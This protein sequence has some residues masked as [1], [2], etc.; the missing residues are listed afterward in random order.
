MNFKL[1][2]YHATKNKLL[3]HNKK[4]QNNKKLII[5]IHQHFK[6]AKQYL[7][8]IKPFYSTILFPNTFNKYKKIVPL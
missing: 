3:N 1:Q 6:I 7:N 8:I 5:L 4:N 2:L